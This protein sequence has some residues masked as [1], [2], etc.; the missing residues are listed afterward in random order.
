[1][2]YVYFGLYDTDPLAYSYAYSMF[3]DIVSAAPSTVPAFG[4]I[5]PR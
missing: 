4:Q 3:D 2:T 5:W 1:M